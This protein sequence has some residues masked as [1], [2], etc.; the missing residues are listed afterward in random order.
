MR[1]WIPLLALVLLPGCWFGQ[2][3]LA[4]S[5]GPPDPAP[6]PR[7][8][9]RVER[10]ASA[11]TTTT[12]PLVCELA[13][14]VWVET[15]ACGTPVIHRGETRWFWCTTTNQDDAQCKNDEGEPAFFYNYFTPAVSGSSGLS[16][17]QDLTWINGDNSY[18]AYIWGRDSI[19][20]R[21]GIHASLTAPLGT[22]RWNFTGA[23]LGLDYAQGSFYATANAWGLFTVA[24]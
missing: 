14:K 1:R 5:F 6:P 10:K 16:G 12:T 13:P 8:P 20:F 23:S 9:A 18:Y 22:F 4:P 2:S 7:P 11:L 15:G 17:T 21:C 3:W 19:R 24:P